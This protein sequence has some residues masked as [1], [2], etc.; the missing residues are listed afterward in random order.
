MRTPTKMTTKQSFLKI[1]INTLFQSVGKIITGALGF[2]SVALLTRYLGPTQYGNFSLVFAYLAFF[3]ILADFGLYT[4]MINHIAK[5]HENKASIYSTFFWIKI[6]LTFATS[7]LALIVLLFFH[8]SFIVNFAICLGAIAVFVSN[9]TG[10]A[11][12]IFQ[13]EIRLGLV[14]MVDI[15]TKVVT[16]IAITVVVFMNAN[17]YTVILAVLIGNISGLFYALYQLK[18]LVS[19]SFTFDFDIE[20]AKKM[21]YKS[22]T[23]GIATFLS[24]TYFK[25]DTIM[26]S[27]MKSPADV[28]IYSLSYKIFENTQVFWSFYLASFFPLLA[29]AHEEKGNLGFKKLISNSL[30]VAGIY[31]IAI[32]VFGYIFA[33]LVIII[34]GGNKF[35]E[36]ILPFRILIFSS[37]FFFINS[38]FYYYFFI[39]NKT[40]ILLTCI[41]LSLLFNFFINLVII[42][43]YGYLGTSYTTI[44]TEAFLVILYTATF[45]RC[46]KS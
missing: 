42:P 20:K 13:S 32:I 41:A 21:F 27:V 25:L 40:H 19:L 24:I 34:F 39:K 6:I 23:I 16:I 7:I 44:A 33:P 2:I 4:T 35:V 18:S 22:V 38:I 43:K 5:N 3:S 10:F 30:L 11:T 46:K 36:S 31:S 1:G 37:F 26:L 12:A 9:L 14:T 29:R 45:V 17:F 8:Y 15:I 28:G